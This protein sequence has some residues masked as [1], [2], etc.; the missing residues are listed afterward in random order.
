MTLRE[1]PS[2]EIFEAYCKSIIMGSVKF[3]RNV[4]VPTNFTHH[5]PHQLSAV[6]LFK[7]TG[8]VGH[9]NM[10]MQ[11]SSLGKKRKSKTNAA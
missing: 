10:R 2:R 7:A 8:D 11:D 6:S 3:D 9:E 4:P 5:P 1:N